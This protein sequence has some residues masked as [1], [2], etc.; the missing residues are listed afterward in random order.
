M[1]PGSSPQGGTTF[2]QC[3]R[4]RTHNARPGSNY[5]TIK[6]LWPWNISS[7]YS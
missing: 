6:K 3:R 5:A 7:G 2:M 1:G 4:A